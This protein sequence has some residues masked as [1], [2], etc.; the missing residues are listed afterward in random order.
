MIELLCEGHDGPSVADRLGLDHGAVYGLSRRSDVLGMVQA[1][2]QRRLDRAAGIADKQSDEWAEH[3]RQEKEAATALHSA[4]IQL[5]PRDAVE[6]KR[7]GGKGGDIRMA[8][9]ECDRLTGALLKAQKARRIAANRPVETTQINT[10]EDAVLQKFQEL[11]ATIRGENAGGGERGGDDGVSPAPPA[12]E[13]PS[14]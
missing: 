13:D 9:E 11:Q 8:I 14:E 10:N 6:I 2:L 3:D 5:I 7:L 4:I 12:S 1:A